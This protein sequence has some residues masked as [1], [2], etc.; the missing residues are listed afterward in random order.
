LTDPGAEQSGMPAWDQVQ[1]GSDTEGSMSERAGTPPEPPRLPV[2]VDDL[3]GPLFEPQ[4]LQPD[5]AAAAE[6]DDPADI[7]ESAF[8]LRLVAA[9]RSMSLG[10]AGHKG[11][12]RHGQRTGNRAAVYVGGITNLAAS[13]PPPDPLEDLSYEEAVQVAARA[14]EAAA[15]RAGAVA[16]PS[17][18]DARAAAALLE[19]LRQGLFRDLVSDLLD[20]QEEEGSGEQPWWSGVDSHISDQA[21]GQG[22]PGPALGA[23][24]DA[25]ANP[26]QG[27]GE[28]LYCK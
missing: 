10:V 26:A 5:E 23:P 28:R 18:E 13:I 8:G 16:E 24:G 12:H 22:S 20:R 25:I 2:L 7:L 11:G 19:A 1:Q 17:P 15:A 21:G 4:P 27:K 14:L 3:F 9:L 6:G